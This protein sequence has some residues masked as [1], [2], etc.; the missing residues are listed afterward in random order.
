MV[1]T[2]HSRTETLF[3]IYFGLLA[4]AVVLG[5]VLA[6]RIFAKHGSGPPAE[7]VVVGTPR[8]ANARA[9]APTINWGGQKR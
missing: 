9:L 2:S 1:F 6:D 3:R 8:D 4:I 7:V 5:G